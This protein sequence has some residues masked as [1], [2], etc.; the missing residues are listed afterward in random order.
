MSGSWALGSV[1]RF[2]T[3][4]RPQRGLCKILRTV[5]TVA[6]KERML[7]VKIFMVHNLLAKMRGGNEI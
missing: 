3:L 1:I 7:R 5:A 4:F 2:G 6:G